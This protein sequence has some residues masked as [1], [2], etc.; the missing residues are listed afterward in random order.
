LAVGGDD[1]AD[2]VYTSGTTGRPKGVMLSHRQTLRLY[3]EWTDLADLREGDRYLIVN[4]FFHTFGWKAGCIAVVIRG[5]RVLPSAVFD[6]DRLVRLIERESITMLPG[7]PISRGRNGHRIAT[8][9][10]VRGHCHHRRKACVGM[11]LRVADDGELLVR[12]YH[13]MK[14]YLDD[15]VATAAAVDPDG[16]LGKAVV[17]CK[18]WP[19]GSVASTVTA[20][21]LL[22]R[23][24]QRMAGFKVPRT[25]VF[26]DALP[27]NATKVMK[28]QLR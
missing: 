13:V 8:R 10:F 14:G 20:D 19:M 18:G 27:L 9:R 12:G 23:C 16:W 2:I 21:D 17:V 6:I 5:A 7:P 25:I 3:A 1:L 24:R 28:D 22:D 11:E 15:P 4:P 26:L